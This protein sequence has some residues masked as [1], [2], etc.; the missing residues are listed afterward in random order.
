VTDPTDTW[1]SYECASGCSPPSGVIVD[2]R[3]PNDFE[4]APTIKCPLCAGPLHFRGKW[5]ATEAGFGSSG[6]SPPLIVYPR[7]FEDLASQMAGNLANFGLVHTHEQFD[8][9][10]AIL[11]RQ[12]RFQ[13]A[14]QLG[15]WTD[16]DDDT[17]VRVRMDKP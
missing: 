5:G 15:G 11:L 3:I 16:D 1:Y 4:E 9:A 7:F 12:L 13:H 17:S 14:L 6:D 8:Q 2:M 10:V